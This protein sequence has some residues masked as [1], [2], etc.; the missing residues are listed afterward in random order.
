[1]RRLT[2]TARL[3]LG[4]VATVSVP[5]HP[6]EE[7]GI[8]FRPLDVPIPISTD[9]AQLVEGKGYDIVL[10][11]AE[12]IFSHIRN[13]E[14]VAIKKVLWFISSPSQILLPSYQEYFKSNSV[15]LILKVADKANSTLFGREF[16]RLG[17]TKWLPL[18]IDGNRFR[19]LH[20]PKL[21]D[22][23]LLGNL[24]P[25]VYPFRLRAINY[26]MNEGNF[27][28]IVKPHYGEDY[29][30]AINHSRIFLT[31]SGIW[32]FPVMKFF[33]SMACGTLLLADDPL[34]AEDLGF[35]AG[36][37]YVSADGAWTPSVDCPKYPVDDTE[38]S[39][40]KN[41]LNRI[42]TFYTT[43]V[44]EAKAVAEQGEKLVR[45]R[46]TDEVRAKELYDTLVKL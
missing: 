15:D 27:R 44:E 37:N 4:R 19:N 30:R 43:H 33:E 2:S 26:L 3:W 21:A 5:R 32:K 22:V 11:Y 42:L 14:K 41:A 7:F 17:K 38:W 23:C 36:E 20:V 25:T 39:F 34:D 12:S 29:V 40:D 24:N 10:V 31:C 28:V 6:L 9:V 45:K 1:M 18:S 13:L 46:H 35:R 8:Q 16:E